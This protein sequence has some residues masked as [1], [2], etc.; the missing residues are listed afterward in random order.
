MEEVFILADVP[1][2]IAG[3]H[4]GAG[5]GHHFLRHVEREPVMVHVV[6][7]SRPDVVEAYEVVRHELE[8]YKPELAEKPKT[9]RETSC[10]SQVPARD[11]PYCKRHVH[12]KW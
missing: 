1:A 5:L 12:S 3:A 4:T 6:D 9:L 2:L 11:L 7:A 10:S 8:L